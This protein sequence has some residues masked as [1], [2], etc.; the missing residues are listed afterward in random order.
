MIP[1]ENPMPVAV[2]LGLLPMAMARATPMRVVPPD[3]KA[4]RTTVRYDPEGEFMLRLRR[5]AEE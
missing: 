2:I 1:V 3:R 5:C 4:S